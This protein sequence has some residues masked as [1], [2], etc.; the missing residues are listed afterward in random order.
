V[1][2]HLALALAVPPTRGELIILAIGSL[3]VLVALLFTIPDQPGDSD[4]HQDD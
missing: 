3:L 4:D 1:L 2:D